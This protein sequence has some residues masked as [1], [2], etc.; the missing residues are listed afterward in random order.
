MWPLI[1]AAFISLV[2][3]YFVS[4]RSLVYI[5]SGGMFALLLLLL[6]DVL[7]KYV[8]I[9][10]FGA[11]PSILLHLFIL[12]AIIL[13]VFLCVEKNLKGN[14]FL[15]ISLGLGMLTGLFVNAMRLLFMR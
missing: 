1:I 15:N 13:V 14:W 5:I 12:G 3:L 11:H 7:M 2:A 6:P 9:D 10:I 4:F 8:L